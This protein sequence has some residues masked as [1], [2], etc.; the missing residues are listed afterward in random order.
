MAF[1]KLLSPFL[2]KK[3]YLKKVTSLEEYMSRRF[4]SK[5][6]SM[7]GVGAAF[8]FL[9]AC[10]DDGGEVREI[11]TS[12]RVVGEFSENILK[13][14]ATP[15]VRLIAEEMG[16][17]Q[18]AVTPENVSGKL[19]S[20][21]G[22]IGDNDGVSYKLMFISPSMTGYTEESVNSDDDFLV[23]FNLKEP[24]AA[25]VENLEYYERDPYPSDEN[26]LFSDISIMFAWVD[27][28]FSAGDSDLLPPGNHIVRQVYAN[29]PDLNYQRGDILY[30]SSADEEF[31]WIDDA[32][33]YD[34]ADPE[35]FNSE[36]P[37]NPVQNSEIASF[38]GYEGG[39]GNQ[40]IP[41]FGL[42][43]PYEDRDTLVFDDFI[44]HSWVFDVVFDMREAVLISWPDG[45]E[46]ADVYTMLK[47][48]GLNF[49]LDNPAGSLRAY[50]D[51]HGEELDEP[52]D[53]IPE[54]GSSDT[55]VSSAS[56][57]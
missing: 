57:E 12:T 27:I 5:T 46:S 51:V 54:N 47:S 37:E 50:V 29:V 22:S 7:V 26:A 36:R 16:S 49:N 35:R 25:H 48:F 45:V 24:Y 43:V 19:I 34:P 11:Q 18:I 52:V 9:S 56:E 15:G 38:S 32:P 28:Q 40:F 2:Y 17:T 8:L 31:Q 42:E 14:T 55:G 41:T 3:F 30:R 4:I 10:S 39:M 53:I 23:D 1:F 20:L 13:K 33:G 44:T 6:F 21:L